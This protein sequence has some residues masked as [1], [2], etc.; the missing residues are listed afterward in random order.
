MNE[1]HP[2]YVYLVESSLEYTDAGYTTVLTRDAYYSQKEAIKRKDE[3][4]SLVKSTPERIYRVQ[5][6]CLKVR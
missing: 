1:L 4:S 2:K 3:I 6:I 5:T